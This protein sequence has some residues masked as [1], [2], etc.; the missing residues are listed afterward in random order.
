M[1]IGG[2]EPVANP[3][4]FYTK[5]KEETLAFVLFYFPKVTL[6][7]LIWGKKEKEKRRGPKK[8]F[9]RSFV[10]FGL[11]VRY[12]LFPQSLHSIL[13]YGSL[14]NKINNKGS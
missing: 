6:V 10:C 3:F 7:G 13:P 2:A 11:F 14:V 8:K 5:S 9:A 4:R 1:E 12:P